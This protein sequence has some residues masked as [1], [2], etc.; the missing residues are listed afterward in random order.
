MPG[1]ISVGVSSDNPVSSGSVNVWMQSTGT[2][3]VVVAGGGVVENKHVVTSRNS[4][5]TSPVV[6]TVSSAIV[7][8]DGKVMVIGV[9]AVTGLDWN[10]K[11]E[12]W[13]V[14]LNSC[15]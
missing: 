6:N 12:A 1:L 9:F 11:K 14:V 13:T 10:K 7:T 2:V 8:G 4:R 15:Y 5:G 3:T